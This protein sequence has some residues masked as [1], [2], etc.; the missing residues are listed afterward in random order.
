VDKEL[1][2]N[3]RFYTFVEKM[4]DSN[5]RER[6]EHGQKEFEN[7]FEYYRKYPKWLYEKYT[8]IDG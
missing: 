3:P 4:Y 2:D 6:R 5:C 7:V 8:S 1:Q